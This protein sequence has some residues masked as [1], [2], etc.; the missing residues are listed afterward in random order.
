MHRWN[1][2]GRWRMELPGTDLALDLAEMGLADL[3]PWTG[4]L[5]RAR[6]AM[7]R[8]EG[9]EVANPDEGR[10][11][12]HYWLRAPER[13]PSPDMTRSILQARETTE[14]I[15]RSLM[16]SLHPERVLHLGI[17]GS[18]LGPELLAQALGDPLGGPLSPTCY[19]VLDNTDP[20][21]FE[22]LLPAVD[23]RKTVV[24]VMSKSGGTPETRN[25][26]LRVRRH[27]E[28]AGVPFAPHAVAVTGEGSDLDRLVVREGWAGRLP[29]WDW[30]GG[31]TSITGPVGLLTM[32]LLGI[33]ARAFLEGAHAMDQATRGPLARDPAAWLTAAWLVAQADR[34]RSMV[35]LPYCDRL[36][37]LGRYLQQLI[38]ESIGKRLDRSGRELRAGLTVYGNKGSTDQHAYIQQLRDGPDDF[39]ATFVEVL[40]PGTAD[41]DLGDGFTA[42]DSLAGFLLGTREALREDG[43]RSLTLSLDGVTPRA[44][45]AVVALFER[46]VGYYGEILG[47]NAYH[48]PGVEAGKKAAAR[49]LQ[50]Q[51][52]LVGALQDEPTTVEALCE[53][54]QVQ[55]R[56]LAW[57]ILHRL[58]RDPTRGVRCVPGSQPGEDRFGR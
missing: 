33:D 34:P 1:D 22:L 15:V 54:S 57:R 27:W 44:L 39:F 16:A 31:R 38:M 45:G 7:A 11:V 2:L 55:D 10:Q 6:E 3:G 56:V 42:G 51:V 30:V 25:A 26:M 52:K 40:H 48:Q 47:I 28:S 8:L 32:A 46:A 49:A 20:A 50:A 35:V 17:G 53:R 58:A 43:K 23:P 24:V 13:A 29:L 21:T 4:D 14:D 36:R 9:G 37:S 19:H 5:V 41:P 12:G 18:A